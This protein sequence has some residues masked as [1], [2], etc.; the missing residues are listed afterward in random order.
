MTQQDVGLPPR[1]FLYT[2][3]QIASLV[4]IDLAA[5]RASY[6]YYEGRTTG[7]HRKD[8]LR[9]RNIAPVGV[10]PDWRISE[11][12]FTRWLRSKHYRVYERVRISDT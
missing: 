7:V 9:A 1:P 12:E 6:L 10:A 2:L 4:G 5:L 11:T 3:D 8:T